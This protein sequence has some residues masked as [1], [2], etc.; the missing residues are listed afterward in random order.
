MTIRN[1]SISVTA[2]HREVGACLVLTETEY[3]LTTRQ[4][5]RG[6]VVRSEEGTRPKQGATEKPR[7]RHVLPSPACQY[8]ADVR[9]EIANDARA[10]RS[11]RFGAQFVRC[12]E[13]RG[14]AR[15]LG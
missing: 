4:H 10:R 11:K 9:T 8:G 15:A 7:R 1:Q 12:V 5:L 2:H 13:H 14:R 6:V 3:L